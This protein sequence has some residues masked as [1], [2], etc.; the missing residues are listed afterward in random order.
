MHIYSCHIELIMSI[1]LWPI[2]FAAAYNHELKMRRENDQH[3]DYLA[4]FLGRAVWSEIEENKMRVDHGGERGYERRRASSE[5]SAEAGISEYNALGSRQALFIMGWTRVLEA[6]G[7]SG[8]P[9]ARVLWAPIETGG[10]NR[11]AVSLR[12]LFA[13]EPRMVFRDNKRATSSSARTTLLR[14]FALSSFPPSP[15]LF[16]SYD[17]LSRARYHPR[18]ILRIDS[19][20]SSFLGPSAFVFYEHQRSLNFIWKKEVHNKRIPIYCISYIVN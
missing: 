16:F 8:P 14:S 18:H 3:I 19:L 15:F 13:H 2:N 1:L 10:V 20:L 4:H 11:R 6:S 17:R 12:S 9:K 5:S 7:G